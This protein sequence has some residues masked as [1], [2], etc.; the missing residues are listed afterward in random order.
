MRFVVTQFPLFQMITIDLGGESIDPSCLENLE[1]PDISYSQ[2]VVLD[3]RAPIWLFSYLVAR[4]HI[5]AW[6]AINQP[7][8]AGAVVV[9]SHT[10]GVFVGSIQSTVFVV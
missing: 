7:Q 2:G 8:L 10:P 4:W 3:G 5:S 6:I 1:L 9:K